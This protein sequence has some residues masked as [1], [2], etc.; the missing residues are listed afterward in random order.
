ME[1][2]K[3]VQR[4]YIEV[5]ESLRGVASLGVVMYH[6]ANST[7]PT[8]KPNPIGA[9]FEWAKLGLNL[10]I[11]VF[12]L[13]VDFLL[14]EVVLLGVDRSELAGV[15]RHQCFPGQAL[16]VELPYEV[17]ERITEELRILRPKTGNRTKTG[18]QA[19]Q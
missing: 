2:I 14:V 17:G 12:Q 10:G 4:V 1:P 7:L 6:F 3:P 19:F 9:Y 18:L 16:A 5:I 15:Q 13:P 11:D 8:I